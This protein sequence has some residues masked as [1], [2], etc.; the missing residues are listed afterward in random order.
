LKGVCTR[1]KWIVEII[2]PSAIEQ[3]IFLSEITVQ[4]P[5]KG[6]LFLLKPYK[7]NTSKMFN[8]KKKMA[9]EI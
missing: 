5:Q 1:N 9:D 2:K 7:K 3:N 4:L 8:M 6:K